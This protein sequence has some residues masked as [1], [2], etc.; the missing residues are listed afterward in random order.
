MKRRKQQTINKKKSKKSYKCDSC[1]SIF[2]I[3]KD[4]QKHVHNNLDCKR[5][6]P[7]SCQ[8][9][10]YVGYEPYGFQK[11]LQYK[12]SCEQF[13]KEKETTT[14]LI[15]DFSPEQVRNTFT[16]P[17]KTSYHYKRFSASGIQDTVQL[18]VT[19]DMFADMDYNSKLDC[20]N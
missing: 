10:P 9:C 20:L 17:K 18:N 11:H 19:N 7:Y 8:F 1:G 14:G 4:Y 16:Q 2:T 6:L 15:L 5:I 3:F 13:Y 12:P